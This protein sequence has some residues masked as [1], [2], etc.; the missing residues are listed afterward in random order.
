MKLKQ[1]KLLNF[2]ISKLYNICFHVAKINKIILYTYIFSFLLFSENVMW[3]KALK[4]ILI[5]LILD[6]NS[7]KK[8]FI[9]QNLKEN[10]VTLVAIF[11]IFTITLK[12]YF[13]K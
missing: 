5:F 2:K 10:P 9:S 6:P 4:E 7:K 12:I 13:K 8:K 11:E 3:F 1:R